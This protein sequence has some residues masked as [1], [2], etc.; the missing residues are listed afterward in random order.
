ME[1]ALVAPVFLLMALGMIEFG[2][3]VMVQQ[4]IT[5]GSREGAR[6]AVLDGSTGAEVISTV[7]NYLTAA[8]VPGASAT[9]DPDPDDPSSAGYGEP[10]SV[11]VS[12]PFR[13]VSWLPAPMFIAGD[14]ALEATAVMRRET[15]Q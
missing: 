12:I 5:N 2:R 8:G 7:E 14:I 11:T 1:F 6:A 9:V 3:M 13:Q 4:V 15:V 10:V